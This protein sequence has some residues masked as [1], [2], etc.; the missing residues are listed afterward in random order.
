MMS[1]PA[2]ASALPLATT[3]STPSSMRQLLVGNF[4]PDFVG[5]VADAVDLQ[6][7]DPARREAVG[8]FRAGFA[9]EPGFDGRPVRN[10]AQFVPF[11][12]LA[13]FAALLGKR[14]AQLAFFAVR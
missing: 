10:D 7:K 1:P 12:I 11:A 6:A 9:V 3:E 5:F 2:C 8:N 13:D 4:Q 14:Q